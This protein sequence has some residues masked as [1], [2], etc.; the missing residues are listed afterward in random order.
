MPVS[1]TYHDAYLG[2]LV[3]ED[4]EARALADVDA[5]GEFTSEWRERL[6]VAWAYVLTAI[7]S[8][9]APDDLFAA[10]AKIYRTQFNALLPL[11]KTAVSSATGETGAG[12]MISIPWER[13]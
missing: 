7:E 2:P 9:R 3:T 1:L 13:A 4:R 6:A 8:Q 12:S 11:A 5:I 10:K